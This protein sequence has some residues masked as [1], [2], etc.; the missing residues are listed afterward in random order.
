MG[1]ILLG[2]VR[3]PKGETGPEGDLQTAE[4]T[5]SIS[6][7]YKIIESDDVDG[8]ALEIHTSVEPNRVYV[9]GIKSTDYFHT[10]IGTK[11]E[12]G[13]G[14][15]QKVQVTNEV[16]EEP[17]EFVWR[18]LVANVPSKWFE[19]KGASVLSA[20]TTATAKD[21]RSG[22][23]YLGNDTY[24]EVGTGTLGGDLTATANDILLGKTAVGSKGADITG[25]IQSVVGSTITPT[26]QE[27]TAVSAGRYVSGDVKVAAI[28]A[29]YVDRGSS[30]KTAVAGDV[31]KG[32]T[33]VGANDAQL[34]GS[35]AEQAA[36]TVGATTSDQTIVAA[37]TIVNGAQIVKAVTNANLVPGNIKNGVTI[38]VASNGSNIFSVAG[39]YGSTTTLTDATN[40]LSGQIAIGN[41]GAT[42]YTGTL[43]A[44]S[45]QT[46]TPKAAQTTLVTAPKKITGNII[47]AGDA[48][49]T[50]ANI[51]KGVTI[52]GIAGSYEGGYAKT[53]FDSTG[54][55]TALGLG[56]PL[57]GDLPWLGANHYDISGK[58]T[59]G[60]F[61]NNVYTFTMTLSGTGEIANKTSYAVASIIGKTTIQSGLL[62]TLTFD[63][64]VTIIGE[65]DFTYTIKTYS[66][67]YSNKS[68]FYIGYYYRSSS[69]ADPT[70]VMLQKIPIT[71]VS[72]SSPHSSSGSFGPANVIN[73]NTGYK[74]LNLSS[75]VFGTDYLYNGTLTITLRKLGFYKLSKLA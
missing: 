29:N 21:V 69:S 71:P 12:N 55:N 74:T 5:V 1:K 35:L 54:V 65:G 47:V 28:P 68:N 26:K 6:N 45:G 11:F 50:A 73:K 19:F 27:Q 30:A 3:G 48:N 43:A 4:G 42:I 15:Q 16:S 13:D 46:Y 31:R 38:T 23:T 56:S 40:L 39:N 20:D 9:Q 22:L 44:Q 52:F 25:S 37:N 66:A 70:R 64:N 33:F 49:L 75:I 41:K 60:A 51:K 58:T 32:R 8:T 2:Y 17:P 67:T 61:S 63:E 18:Y 72:S 53:V 57:T 10:I 7:I 36:K 34:T 62:K 24:D 59:K 14:W